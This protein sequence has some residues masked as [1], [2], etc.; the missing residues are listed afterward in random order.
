MTETFIPKS[1]N[2]DQITYDQETKLMT[3]VFKSG[4]AWEYSG[5]PNEVYLGLQHAPS[6]G[7]YFFRHVRG[8]FQETEI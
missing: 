5:V 7:S 1:S 3:I 4:G 2:L 6:P 8:R